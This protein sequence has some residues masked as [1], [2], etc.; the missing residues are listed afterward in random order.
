MKFSIAINTL[1]EHK[2][3]L[4]HAKPENSEVLNT[5]SV[6]LT[7]SNELSVVGPGFQQKI[8]CVPILWGSVII[9]F[10]TWVYFLKNIK[11]ITTGNEVIIAAEDGL[12][13]LGGL[14]I[15]NEDI[16][17]IRRNKSAL[18]LPSNA[19]AKMLVDFFLENDAESIKN[20][21]LEKTAIAVFKEFSKKVKIASKSLSDYEITSQDILNMIADKYNIKDRDSFFARF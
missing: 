4:L 17:V 20:A 5:S 15:K 13:H 7:V 2:K 16:K 18:K 1:I 12:L 14:D 3:V 6:T 9:P 11:K 21:G 8:P 19:S 10:R